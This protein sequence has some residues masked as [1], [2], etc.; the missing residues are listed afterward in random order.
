MLVCV[1]GGVGGWVGAQ[2][3][4][5]TVARVININV[6]STSLLLSEHGRHSRQK[7]GMAAGLGASG[8]LLPL[9]GLQQHQKRRA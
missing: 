6:D 8:H 2:H 5:S 3:G 7:V 9:L 1:W 4:L